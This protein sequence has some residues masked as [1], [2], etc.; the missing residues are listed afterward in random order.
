MTSPP[1]RLRIGTLNVQSLSSKLGAVLSLM[2]V[3]QLH[4]LCLQETCLSSDALPAV[5]QAADRAGCTFFKG[6]QTC[7]LAGAP[8]AGVSF[9]TRWPAQPVQMPDWPTSAGRVAALRVFRPRARPLLLIGVYLHAS[10]AFAA[11]SLLDLVLPWAASSGEDFCVTGDFNLPKSHW[12]TSY[13]L[14]AGH[15]FDADEVVGDPAQ[16]PGTRRN[17]AGQ[18]TGSV[19]DYLLHSPALTVCARAQFQA[20]A[21]HDLVFYSLPVLGQPA[22]WSWP[23]RPRLGPSPPVEGAWERCWSKHD[24]AFRAALATADLDA[25][26]ALVSTC[27]AETVCSKPPARP[28]E[29][30]CGSRVA[31]CQPHRTAP[32]YQGFLE[33]RLRRLS[34]RAAEFAKDCGNQPLFNA[35]QRD[36]SHLSV[37]FPSLLT[38]PWGLDQAAQHAI[39]LADQQAD[40]DRSARLQHWQATAGEDFTRLCQWIR[41]TVPTNPP[42]HPGAD[43]WVS[44]LHPQEQVE[45]AAETLR[46]L[47]APAVLPQPEGFDQMRALIGSTT[48]FPL[49]SISG[50]AIFARFKATAKKST[51][52]D[53]W[54]SAAFVA[55]GPA[56]SEVLAQLWAACLEFSTMPGIWKHIRVA[57]LPKPDGT[58][59]PISIASAAYRTCMTCLLRACREWFLSWADPELVGGIPGRD[60]SRTH[61]AL[62]SS[63]LEARNR[64]LAFV[65]AKQDVRKCFDTVQWDLALQ[66][67]TWLGAPPKLVSLLRCFY[68]NQ[69]RWLAVRGH[70]AKESVVP[71]RSILQGCPASVGLLNGL[72][73]LWVRHLRATAPNV[74]RSVYL[75]DRAMWAMGRHA[76]DDLCT[77]LRAAAV[78]DKAICLEVHPQKLACWATRAQARRVLSVDPVLCGPLVTSFKLLGITY[79]LATGTGVVAADRLDTVISNR[80][81]RIAIAARVLPMRRHLLLA[82]VLS[83]I[84]WLGPWTS[85]PHLTA[86]G[87]ARSIEAAVSRIVSAR[88]P[89]LLW[90]TW[91]RP[92]LHPKF[93]LAFAA[94]SHEL[95]RVGSFLPP[96]AHVTACP[97]LQASLAI[98]AWS[99]LP[100][101]TWCTPFGQFSPG[102]LTRAVALKVAE[103]SWLRLLWAA[104]AKS[105]GPLEADEHIAL[106]FHLAAASSHPSGS[107]RRVLFAAAHD[108]R[109]L[110]RMHLPF[111][112]CSCGEALPTRTH[113]TFEC[114]DDPFPGVQ[115]SES[116]RRFLVPLLT[117]LPCPTWQLPEVSQD[118][119]LA[120]SQARIVEEAFLVATDGSSLQAPAAKDLTWFQHAGWGI[121]TSRDLGFFGVV[122]G[123][124]RSSAAAERYALLVLACAAHMLQVPVCVLTDNSALVTSFVA[125]KPPGDLG[126][127]W[128]MIRHLLPVGSSLHWVPA[129]GRRSTWTSGIPLVSTQEARDLNARADLSACSATEPMKATFSAAQLACKTAF[130]WASLSVERQERLTQDWHDSVAARAKAIGRLRD[131]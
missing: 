4:A 80:C 7:N 74:S 18:L 131:M 103:D 34:R 119:L 116:E 40:K 42:H 16:L 130:D 43:D 52:L 104:D 46:A 93:A 47:W 92:R 77:A 86:Q 112:S 21:D 45:Q 59:R 120:L 22:R 76:A 9:V 35:I 41:A 113:V 68:S 106:A 17:A 82:L 26:W 85:V 19:I 79:R 48:E 56:A 125:D 97:A 102:F 32:T 71:T 100:D 30:A 88:S 38:Q 64:H 44:P 121:A 101:G 61:D 27:L 107:R 123:L 67:W 28:P 89:L 108:T 51:G 129:H 94:I 63:L 57:L 98:F 75:D 12:P 65:G 95:R 6:A 50:K 55:A 31:P 33:R 25:A 84:S 70:F 78:A 24:V 105:T 118:L 114:P 66:A 126:A 37:D 36:V 122:P 110:Q 62:F 109:T 14:A 54:G 111:H 13:A 20:V 10:D 60:M 128:A 15:L 5:H 117:G 29:E 53:G 124:D 96:P 49:P 39:A 58:L 81:R 83:L 1:S 73:L 115:R 8:Y 23:P 69:M 87:W 11:A 91:A 127:Y 90:S 99:I 2:R 3:H 72:M